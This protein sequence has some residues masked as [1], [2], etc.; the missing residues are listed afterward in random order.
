[1]FLRRVFK[2][3]LEIHMTSSYYLLHTQ[4]NLGKLTI[5]SEGHA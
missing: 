3:N 1:M 5:M 2:Q 4:T